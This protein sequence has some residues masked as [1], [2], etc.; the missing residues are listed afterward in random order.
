MRMFTIILL[1]TLTIGF[2]LFGNETTDSPF[3][4]YKDMNQVMELAK[5]KPTVLFFKADWCPSCTLAAKSFEKNSAQLK[6]VNLVVVNYDRSGNL[7]VKYG[8]TYQHTFVQVS[9]KGDA[10]VKWNGGATA[11]LLKKIVKGD[12]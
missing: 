3:I 10:L 8:V 1:I 2:P 4:T 12:K 7:Q 5:S 6:D 9:S 11:E